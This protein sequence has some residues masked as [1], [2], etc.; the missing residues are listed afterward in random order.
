MSL[1]RIVFTVLF[2]VMLNATAVAEFWD[3]GMNKGDARSDFNSPL[4]GLQAEPIDYG[5]CLHPGSGYSCN[6]PIYWPENNWTVIGNPTDTYW[7]IHH[8]NSENWRVGSVNG[9]GVHG[10]PG[11]TRSI[12]VPG[13]HGHGFH[14]THI[15][16]RVDGGIPEDNGWHFIINTDL[17]PNNER[18]DWVDN[19]ANA[20][21]SFGAHRDRGN[22]GE[23]PATLNGLDHWLYGEDQYLRF[24]AQQVASDSGTKGGGSYIS[25]QVSI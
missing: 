22:G 9:G 12:G 7:V 2:L 21:L 14:M 18:A 8:N 1:F 10:P 24:E 15:D 6:G 17:I 3:E 5:I 4:R 23:S 16:Y 19:G 20:H 25:I 13:E 11:Q